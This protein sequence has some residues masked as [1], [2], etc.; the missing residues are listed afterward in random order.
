M[1]FIS[2]A[3]L[4]LTTTK[5]SREDLIRKRIRS[6]REA[7]GMSQADLAFKLGIDERSYAR[8]ERGERKQLDLHLLIAVASAM[9][10]DLL[11]LL[12]PVLQTQQQSLEKRIASEER[13][14]DQPQKNHYEYIIAQLMDIIESQ[15]RIIEEKNETLRKVPA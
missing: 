4:N 10:M 2:K 1:I 9:D 13:S 14:K 15:K 12:A 3:N 11:N 6:L 8:L 5:M 7:A